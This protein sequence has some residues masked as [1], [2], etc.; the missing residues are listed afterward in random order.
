MREDR[1][2]RLYRRWFRLEALLTL[3]ALLFL[4][5]LVME[6]FLFGAWT[7]AVA[8]SGLSLAALAQTLMIV[9]AE[10]GLAGF[11]VVTVDSAGDD[12]GSQPN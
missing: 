1:W 3:A 7:S 10:L 5:G 12:I 2:A 8:I 11:L 4:A 9:G 6:V